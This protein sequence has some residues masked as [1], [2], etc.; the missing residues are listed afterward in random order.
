MPFGESKDAWE[1]FSPWLR[2]NLYKK[3]PDVQAK[4]VLAVL[5]AL[6]LLGVLMLL[7]LGCCIK[8]CCCS[9]NKAK[10]DQDQKTTGSGS[11]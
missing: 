3:R 7:C 1:A 4:I 2:E 11:S 10:T 5:G 9:S 8:N 6:I